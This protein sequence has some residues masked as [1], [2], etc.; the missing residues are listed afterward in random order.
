MKNVKEGIVARLRHTL[1][2]YPQLS[3]PDPYDA[4]LSVCQKLDA[5]QAVGVKPIPLESRILGTFDAQSK[6]FTWNQQISKKK[7]TVTDSTWDTESP[8]P[9]NTLKPVQITYTVEDYF[10]TANAVLVN[11]VVN[12]VNNDSTSVIFTIGNQTTTAPEGASS[13]SLKGLF[14]G[15]VEFVLIVGNSGAFETVRVD[16]P[17]SISTGCLLVP[18]LPVAI[19]YQPPA[20]GTGQFA[21]LEAAGATVSNITS[22]DIGNPESSKLDT[23]D[24]AAFTLKNISDLAGLADEGAVAAV[25]QLIADNLEFASNQ[26]DNAV[27]MRV[28]TTSTLEIVSATETRFFSTPTL[29]PGDGDVIVYLRDA[30]FA[31]VNHDGDVFIVPLGYRG[32]TPT[33]VTA[34]SLKPGAE[35]PP[36]LPDDVRAALLEL[37]PVAS[38]RPN[39]VTDAKRFDY[40]GQF[41]L[42][43]GVRE[44]FSKIHTIQ[45]STVAQQ[46]FIE[47]TP[48]GD[49]VGLSFGPS[50]GT[51]AGQTVTVTLDVT[52]PC[53]FEIYYD[54]LF[55]TFAYRDLQAQSYASK[56]QY[57]GVLT[58]ETGVPL[59]GQ[60]VTIE[61]G[62]HLVST[63]T[64]D[65]G[66]YI[67]RSS[68]LEPGAA[69]LLV[70][71]N[72]PEPKRQK[73]DLRYHR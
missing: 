51:S 46:T 45:N 42:P 70:P 5:I 72:E 26:Q 1:E 58:D 18:A 23:L 63:I 38:G 41:V 68:T 44:S 57:K 6:T 39:A 50:S 47:K 64:N 10:F 21:M 65:A 17:E 13:V 48:K 60:M 62:G 24:V 35:N 32:L 3:P 36:D 12:L 28:N 16:R 61:Q 59:P 22:T 33:P 30:L 14:F 69:H 54:R 29:G 71:S 25:G 9:G 43:D 2:H 19:V 34:A 20:D 4:L 15:Q 37:D 40:V 56:A 52:G 49:E 7:R 67:I 73:V 66:Q 11:L 55:G 8:G 53:D 27:F 31:F